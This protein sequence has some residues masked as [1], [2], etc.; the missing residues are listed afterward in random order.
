MSIKS[1][2]KA[3][4]VLKLV[5]RERDGLKVQE[6][7]DRLDLPYATAYRIIKTLER[8]GYLDF[9]ETHKLYRVGPELLLLLGPVSL[10]AHL[11]RLVYPS[12]SGLSSL[13]GETAHLAVRYGRDVLYMNSIPSRHAPMMYTPVG[14]RAPLHSSALGKALLAFAPD[15]EIQAILANYKFEGFTPHT[16]TTKDAMWKA[17]HDIREQ[18]YAVD[19]DENTI[20]VRCTASVVVNQV[21][22]AEAAMSVSAPSS[23][24]PDRVMAETF[25][26]AVCDACR[27]ASKALGGELGPDPARWYREAMSHR[28]MS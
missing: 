26:G 13:T 3:L 1:V 6:I 18:G 23:R 5:A 27:E 8:E 19:W 28:Q 9:Q 14:T 4:A 15:E 11:G 10:Q 24:L 20:G 12:L 22:M 16:I 17:I 7:S 21:G 25:V 2:Q